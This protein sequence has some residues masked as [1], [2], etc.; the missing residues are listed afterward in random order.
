MIDAIAMI[1]ILLLFAAVIYST[2]IQPAI[3]IAKDAAEEVKPSYTSPVGLFCSLCHG[4]A[5]VVSGDEYARISRA[6]APVYCSGC[7]VT[8]EAYKRQGNL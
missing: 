4:S 5:S 7:T 3:E 2:V 8:I 6:N 1:A